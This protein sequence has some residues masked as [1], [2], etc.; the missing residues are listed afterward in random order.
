MGGRS[1]GGGELRLTLRPCPFATPTRLARTVHLATMT[2]IRRLHATAARSGA[3]A[4]PRLAAILIPRRFR[5]GFVRLRTVGTM[6]VSIVVLRR[7]ARG[8]V[9]KVVFGSASRPP[10]AHR[11]SM[12]SSPQNALPA[13]SSAMP[14][15]T[16][17]RAE[18]TSKLWFRPAERPSTSS[19][20][21]PC[22]IARPT[23]DSS[24]SS[25]RCRRRRSA[26]RPIDTG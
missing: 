20:A 9:G 10:L 6:R 19:R 2:D 8:R 11:Y 4:D 24:S 1:G 22:S 21:P 23:R 26:P 16:H 14:P 15:D 7:P 25:R 13:R 17:P 18:P 5:T 12:S 3:A